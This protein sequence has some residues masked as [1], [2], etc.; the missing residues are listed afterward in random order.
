MTQSRPHLLPKDHPCYMLDCSQPRNTGSDQITTR[1][2]LKQNQSSRRPPSVTFPPGLPARGDPN[3]T[4][5]RHTWQL[6]V[7][8]TSTGRCRV[9][10]PP[11]VIM[12]GSISDITLAKLLTSVVCFVMFGWMRTLN[13]MRRLYPL[14]TK[15]TIR[16]DIITGVSTAYCNV[17]GSYRKCST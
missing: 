2:S 6:K 12:L 7:I 4:A 9:H 3:V 8:I 15:I 11:T 10:R 14:R 13:I 5:G 1:W 17:T 16:L